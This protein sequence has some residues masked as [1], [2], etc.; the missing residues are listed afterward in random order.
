VVT[1]IVLQNAWRVGK[2]GIDAGTNLVPV[3]QNYLF[4]SVFQIAAIA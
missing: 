3:S 1:E 4:P 2:D